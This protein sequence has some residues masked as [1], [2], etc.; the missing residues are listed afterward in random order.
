MHD[1]NNSWTLWLHSPYDT[2]WSRNSYKKYH[3]FTH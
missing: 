3:H 2:D 1:L